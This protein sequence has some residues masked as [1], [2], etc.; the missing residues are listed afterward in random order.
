MTFQWLLLK[1][2][3]GDYYNGTQ[4]SAN[5]YFIKIWAK[6]SEKDYLDFMN[7]TSGEYLMF[8]VFRNISMRKFSAKLINSY[9]YF[10]TVFPRKKLSD[11]Y[12]NSSTEI[13][14]ST[15]RLLADEFEHGRACRIIKTL[16]YF[17][18]IKSLIT[19]TLWV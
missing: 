2:K 5:F 17:F 18:P 3:M 8:C 15:W 7:L 6:N 14:L 16:L 12:L 1:P 4:F 9:S 19:N 11:Y 10:T 13:H